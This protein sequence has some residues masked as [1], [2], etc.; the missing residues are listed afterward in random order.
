MC[1]QSFWF[2]RHIASVV[3]LCVGLLLVTFVITAPAGIGSFVVGVVG[4]IVIAKLACQAS[5]PTMPRV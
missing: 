5:K 1:A 3:L 4:A 2:V